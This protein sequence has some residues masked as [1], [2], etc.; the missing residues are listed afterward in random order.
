MILFFSVIPVTIFNSTD[1]CLIP[2][3]REPSSL[4]KSTNRCTKFYSKQKKI[5]DLD[6]FT[7]AQKRIVRSTTPLTEFQAK[8]A[9][10]S[11][12]YFLA[13]V[14]AYSN[15]LN[16]TGIDLKD[17]LDNL[18]FKEK[19]VLYRKINKTL[20]PKG[21]HPQEFYDLLVELYKLSHK[22][23]LDKMPLSD[24]VQEKWLTVS[25][26]TVRERIQLELVTS[27]FEKNFDLII[28]DPTLRSQFRTWKK[29]L[30]PY[31]DYS[32]FVASWASPMAIQMYLGSSGHLT[33]TEFLN[34]FPTYLPK[35]REE[36]QPMVTA[37]EIILMQ[38]EGLNAADETIQNR[39]KDRLSSA[40]KSSLVRKTWAALFSTLFIMTVGPD[41]YQYT[42]AEYQKIH[43]LQT[44]QQANAEN[45][46]LGSVGD[47]DRQGMQVRIEKLT[48]MTVE[49]IIQE[50]IDFRNEFLKNLKSPQLNLSSPDEILYY[51]N[52]RQVLTDA[53]KNRAASKQPYM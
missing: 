32:L 33:F 1:T 23:R 36:N 51:N 19:K 48:E 13:Y 9:L 30:R 50:D 29:K 26:E 22:T 49:E 42:K 24:K 39:V 3:N 44:E 43:E 21:I 14:E 6:L 27:N 25:D 4:F 2:S 35:T 17:L 8:E 41:L 38:N 46:Y 53:K 7:A 45:E 18:K 11:P 20:S 31:A 37:D 34:F 47:F 16:K 40:K 15:T 52:M 5:F 10:E 12:E 28:K